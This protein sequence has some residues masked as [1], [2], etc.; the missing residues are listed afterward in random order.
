VINASYVRKKFTAKNTEDLQIEKSYALSA[1]TCI[2][3][4]VSYELSERQFQLKNILRYMH[5]NKCSAI[6]DFRFSAMIC[7]DKIRKILVQLR[8]H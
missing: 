2:V 8:Y 1:S 3:S 6:S 5:S 4:L 7:L